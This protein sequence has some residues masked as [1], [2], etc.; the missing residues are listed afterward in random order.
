MQYRKLGRT[1][2]KISALG[3]G[4]IPIQRVGFKETKEIIDK[5]FELGINFFDTARA[6]SDSEEKLGYALQDRSDFV[7]SS[8]S[9]NPTKGGIL[10]DIDLSLR[11]LKL[12]KIDLYHAH[13]IRDEGEFKRIMGKDGAMKGLKQ[14]RDEGKIDFIGFSGHTAEVVKEIMETNEFD[15]VMIPFNFLERDVEDL[16]DLANGLDTGVIVMKPLAGGAIK[17]TSASLKFILQYGISSVIPGMDSPGQ[18]VKNVEVFKN[19]KI[20]DEE[21]SELENETKKLGKNFCHRCEY[22]IPCPQGLDIPLILLYGVYY[23]NYGLEKWSS[24]LYKLLEVKASDCAKCGAC[25]EKCPYSLPIRE[26][27]DEV[28]EIFE[29]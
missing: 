26:M 7:I 5:C 11:N 27:L 23:K 9:K 19:L 4:G 1:G 6:Y 14:A 13:F 28:A 24:S 8:K 20:S 18:V 29:K 3:F 21:L 2:L 22:C 10:R 17:N 12:E 25:E 16:I 15:S